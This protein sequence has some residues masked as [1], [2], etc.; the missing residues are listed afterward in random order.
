MDKIIQHELEGSGAGLLS[1]KPGEKPARYCPR[2][3]KLSRMK[4]AKQTDNLELKSSGNLLKVG[5]QPCLLTAEFL[6]KETECSDVPSQPGTV[7]LCI[8]SAIF[9]VVALL[10][11]LC[12]LL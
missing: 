7:R 12:S 9:I 10:S 11:L 6:G 5:H 8:S 2:F 3:E 4:C 1:V